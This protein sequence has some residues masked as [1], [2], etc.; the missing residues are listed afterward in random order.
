MNTSAKTEAPVRDARAVMRGRM[1]LLLI[2][3]IPVIVI[4]ASSWLWYFVMSGDLDL[5]GRL[6]TANNGE[7]VR[8]PR[9]IE[10][11][12]LNNGQEEVFKPSNPPRW[13]LVVP[14]AG[15]VCDTACEERL[16]TTRQIHQSLGK[17]LGRVQRVFVTN[18]RL[19]N[20]TMDVPELSDGRPL[21]DSFT[22]Y[23]QSEQ[24]GMS[25]WQ[26]S[27]TGFGQLF[28]ELSVSPDSWYLMDPSGWVMMRYDSSI[29]YKDVIS[30]LKFLIKNSNG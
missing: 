17:E 7:L 8:P 9:Q 19:A 2:A 14:V 3:G 27:E 16:Y 29:D 21:P 5:V 6:G 28:S 23:L 11:A 18:G 12:A 22:A 24:R 25:A 30:D 13:S 20:I 15:N 26:A 10:Q 4:L 1:T